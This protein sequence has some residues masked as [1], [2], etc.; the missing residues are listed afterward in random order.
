MRAT[1]WRYVGVG[2][3]RS[4]VTGAE[5]WLRRPSAGTSIAVSEV[6][7]VNNL[8]GFCAARATYWVGGMCLEAIR[9]SLRLPRMTFPGLTL[10]GSPQ[11]TATQPPV[12]EQAC[13]VGN[14][15]VAGQNP[16]PAPEL[17][18]LTNTRIFRVLGLQRPGA[19][20]KVQRPIATCFEPPTWGHETPRL[21]TLKLCR[22]GPTTP[23]HRIFSHRRRIFSKPPVES[24]KCTSQHERHYQNAGTQDQ[25]MLCL[26]QVE[27]SDPAHEQ[28]A[29]R[30]IQ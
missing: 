16:T 21:R 12:K 11:Y 1:R 7:G 19:I 14:P 27:P 30:K 5:K 15:R 4:F 24:T 6:G 29:N 28:I 9:R 2:S 18:N 13:G 10:L 25:N 22:I 20:K 23:D 26:A 3:H 17:G 8:R